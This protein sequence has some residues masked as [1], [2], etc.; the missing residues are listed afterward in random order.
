MEA[1]L[2]SADT[3]EWIVYSS[4][5]SFAQNSSIGVAI[6]AEFYIL[7]K[8]SSNQIKVQRTGV[9]VRIF[10]ARFLGGGIND[11]VALDFSYLVG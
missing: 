10:T 11:L 8:V 5:T 2:P 7:R 9:S 6:C 4:N 3:F 1:S